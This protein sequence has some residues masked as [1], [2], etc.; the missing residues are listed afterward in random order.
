M[1]DVYKKDG[2]TAK[3]VQTKIPTAQGYEGIASALMVLA[4]AIDELREQTGV[5]EAQ[6]LQQLAEEGYKN[7]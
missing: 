1:A 5:A 6:R 7:G 3:A 2:P 4:R